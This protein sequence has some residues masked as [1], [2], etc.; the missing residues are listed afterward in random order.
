MSGLLRAWEM[1]RLMESWI[2]VV[3]GRVTKGVQS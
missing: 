1:L 3:V 2:R